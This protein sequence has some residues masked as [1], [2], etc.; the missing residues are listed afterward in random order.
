VPPLR[1]LSP[2]IS[3]KSHLNDSI[4]GA[5]GPFASDDRAWLGFVILK[6]I[7]VAHYLDQL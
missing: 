7:G 2:R 1:R 6:F 3:T 4:A 5:P